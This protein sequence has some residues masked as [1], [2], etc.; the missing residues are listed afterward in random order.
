M[1]ILAGEGTGSVVETHATPL[2]PG[3]TAIVEATLVTSDRIGFPAVRA[4]ARWIRPALEARARR[5]WVEDA[6]YAER[7][8]AL[9]LAQGQ[10][11]ERHLAVVAEGDGAK[12]AGR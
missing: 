10:R 4:A 3:R 7:T 9:R 5:L 6:A 2:G 11:R 12:A 1:T 8:Y